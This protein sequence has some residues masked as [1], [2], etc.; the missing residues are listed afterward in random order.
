[1]SDHALPAS[2]PADAQRW[3]MLPAALAVHLCLGQAYVMSALQGP[4]THLLTGRGRDEWTPG[5]F[6]SVLS[7]A[8]VMFGVGAALSAPWL[9][10]GYSRLITALAAPLFGASF[11]V[12]AAGVY[13][14]ELWLL[15]VGF[16]VLGGLGLGFGYVFPV[17]TL[18]EWFPQR[19]GL[20]SGLVIAG[21][22]GGAMVGIPL[23]NTL[24]DFFHTTTSPGVAEAFAI[25]GAVCFLVMM[26]AATVLR[27]PVAPSAEQEAQ[28]RPD[29][30]PTNYLG[31]VRTPQ[32]AL[33]WVVLMAN[34]AAGISVLDDAPAILRHT[35]GGA[36]TPV[37]VAS[38]LGLLSLFNMGGHILSAIA[39]DPLG[40]RNT[41]AVLIVIGVAMHTTVTL[42]GAATNIGTFALQCAVMMLLYGASFATIPAYIIDC[43]GTRHGGAL[44]AL[45]LTAWPAGLLASLALHTS[46]LGASLDGLPTATS[47]IASPWTVGVL[48]VALACNAFI[49][50]PKAGPVAESVP[51]VA[52]HGPSVASGAPREDSPHVFIR[53][54]LW[55][56]VGI[57]LAWGLLSTLKNAANLEISGHVAATLLPLFLGAGVTLA[58]CRLDRSCFAVRGV[59]G[60]Y[61][62]AV[63][64]L[65]SLYASLMA[66]EVWQKSARVASLTRSEVTAIHAAIRI[67]EGLH[68]DDHRVRET[69]TLLTSVPVETGSGATDVSPA[70]PMQ[71]LYVFAADSTFFAGNPAASTAFY[72]SLD[73][74]SVARRENQ[75]ARSIHLSGEKLFTLMLF[76]FLTQV[77]IAYCHAGNARAL[78]TAVMLFSVAF[79]AAVGVLELMDRD[80]SLAPLLR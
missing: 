32:F 55:L 6:G 19:R 33:L 8:I 69:M 11:L 61:F 25:Q 80:A 73:D 31:A 77:A 60:P 41:Y 74:I 29:G 21:F 66:S 35:L 65:F 52:A 47:S 15:Y 3:L 23:T 79:A 54:G 53:V 22:G 13:T 30:S 27:R 14:H 2:S 62:A 49:K 17:V 24:I 26:S 56:L 10:R 57:P 43:F 76:G 1:M 34:V 39:S 78:A 63:A 67:A 44:Y 64:L 58:I 75:A 48:S 16:G 51:A 20:M 18:M 36:A 7:V 4:L 28:G 40:R 5:E 45:V 37:V 12:A 9:A 68:P 38:F 70:D 50:L 42:L 46:V 59:V 71:R 72:R